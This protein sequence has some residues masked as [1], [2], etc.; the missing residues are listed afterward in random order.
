VTGATGAVGPRVVRA[1]L[2]AGY[3]VRTLSNV[4]AGRDVLPPGVDA[5]IGDVCDSQAVRAAAA[6]VESVVHL[7]ALLHQFENVNGLDPEY[8]RVNVGGTE[9]V[10][11]AA[12]AEGARRVVLLS[13]IAVYGP[14]SG[15]LIDESTTPR[16]DTAYGRTKLAAERAVLS[17]ISGGGRIGTVLRAAAAYG[18]RVKG[19]YRRLAEAIARRRY[20]P[21]GRCA[22][23]RTVVHDRDLADAVVL[24]VG[25]PAAAGAV[26]NVS[27]G[28]VHTLADIVSAIY[29]ALGRRPPRLYVPLAAARAATRVS[30]TTARLVG[31]RP[32][33]TKS[34]LDKYT[35]DIAVDATLIQRSLGF[36]PAVDLDHGWHETMDALRASGAWSGI[37]V[38][39]R[40]EG[41]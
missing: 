15:Q 8:E 1:C 17:A 4:A 19:N 23:R 29:R 2:A 37:T 16:P 40:A 5:R 11:R 21:L 18:P 24:A 35:E 12:M 33:V 31:L 27:D 14:S 6:G 25:H 32:L 28:H 41:E 39:I 36:A 30:E 20:V 22:N 9:N 34:L 3:S 10:V 7:A 26:F 13:T 38:P